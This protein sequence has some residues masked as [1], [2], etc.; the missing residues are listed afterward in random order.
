LVIEERREGE[1]VFLGETPDLI[2]LA[3]LDVAAPEGVRLES[4]FERQ[5]HPLEKTTLNDVWRWMSG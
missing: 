1:S 5:E 4:S 3:G 2:Y